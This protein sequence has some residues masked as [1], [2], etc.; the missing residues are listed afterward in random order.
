MRK[1]RLPI[2]ASLLGAMLCFG[3]ANAQDGDQMVQ[4][5]N[6]SSFK[7]KTDMPN[8]PSSL[9]LSAG[10][11]GLGLEYSTPLANSFNLRVGFGYIPKFTIT[12]NTVIGQ[13]D[14]ENKIETEL[15]QMHFFGDWFMPVMKPAGFHLTIGVSGFAAAKGNVTTRPTGEIY[16]GEI[17]VN[18]D[19]ERMGTVVS[20]L[21]R[22]GMAVYAG[23]G[24]QNIVN[25][26]HFGLS[27]D[28]GTYYS[29]STPE[30]Q[31]TTSGYLVGNEVNRN[32]LREN[33]QNYR[34]LPTL[35]LGFNYKF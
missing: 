2:V 14:V 8:H 12:Q 15:F 22:R 24:W 6:S 5:G 9:G 4:Q 16:Y 32:Q 26:R 1:M 28:L 20:T 31:M 18:D 33:L 13:Y 35:Q 25:T 23:I 3:T 19:P 11:S 17:P 10:S 34:W 27:L 29:I 21:N 30:V 7:E